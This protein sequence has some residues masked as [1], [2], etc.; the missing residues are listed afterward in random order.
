MNKIDCPAIDDDE[1]IDNLS[2]NKKLI[3][4]SRINF[5]ATKIKSRYRDY[6]NAAGNPFNLLY[7]RLPKKIGEQLK[8]HFRSP[9]KDLVFIKSWRNKADHRVCP[10]CGSLH[11]GTLDHFFPQKDF[12]AFSI[13]SLN[14]VPACKCNSKRQDTLIGE[15]ANQR[16]LHPYFDECLAL[17]LVKAKFENLGEVP[18]ISLENC[19]DHNHPE[20]AAVNFHIEKIVRKTSVTGYLRDKWA[21]LCRKPSLV[22]RDLKRNP[23]TIDELKMVLEEELALLDDIHRGKNNWDSIFIAGLL[24]E[25]VLA[26]LFIQLSAQKR[27]EDAPLV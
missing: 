24:D 18:T 26:W 10:M 8:S 16:I 13:F 6:K 23:V 3:S 14:L 7:V 12:N 21:S 19:M 11:S 27:I 2:K 5:H 4:H 9:P 20:Y 17:R 22:V 1:V 15:G 25:T